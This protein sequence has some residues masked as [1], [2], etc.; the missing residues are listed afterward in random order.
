MLAAAATLSASSMVPAKTWHLEQGGQWK[1][2]SQYLLAVSQAKKLVNTGQCAAAKKA[3]EQ[4]KK[5]FP[6]IVAPDPT[7]LK[8][9]D[10]F[11]NAEILFCKGKFTKALRSYDKFLDKHYH[12]S[13]LYEVA[14]DRQFSIGMAFLSGRKKAVLRIFKIKG[15]AEGAEIMKSITNRV[16]LDT[17]IGIKAAKAVAQSYEKREKF[18]D[19]YE[20]WAELSLQWETG[21]IAKDAL[22]GMARCKH[23]AYKGPK[24]DASDLISAKSYY[25]K[26]GSQYPEHAQQIHINKILSQINEQLAYKQFTIGRYYQKTWHKQK[27]AGE[28]DPAN[29]YYQTIIDDDTWQ[30]T[31][32][33]KMAD[34][35]LK[36]KQSP[37]SSRGKKVKK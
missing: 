3:L 6:K 27:D 22:L 31:T 5:D 14:L 13:E 23:A 15:Y 7:S 2:P 21:Q 30:G 20:K 36:D 35:M 9:F 33:A 18:N 34:K 26:F 24:Y 16:G 10:A 32:A 1:P 19:A 11:V 25:E 28:I 8:A 29:L 17:P 37:G 12:E 4:L